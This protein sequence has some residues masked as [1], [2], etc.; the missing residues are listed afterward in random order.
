MRPLA[1]LLAVILINPVSR[2]AALNPAE[3]SANQQNFAPGDSAAPVR[4]LQGFCAV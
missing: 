3:T 1:T 4:D 2:P